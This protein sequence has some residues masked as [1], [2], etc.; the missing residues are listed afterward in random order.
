MSVVVL[1][2]TFAVVAVAAGLFVAM[3]VKDKPFYGVLALGL[4]L[5]PGTALTFTYV[6]L[7]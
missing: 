1:V 4:L 2:L 3:F 5:G 7:G 6:A